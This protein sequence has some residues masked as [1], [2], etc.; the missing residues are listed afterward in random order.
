MMTERTSVLRLLRPNDAL[1]IFY[2]GRSA[3]M[4]LDLRPLDVPNIM[5]SA[6]CRNSAAGHAGGGEIGLLIDERIDE[7]FRRYSRL[8]SE[9]R[10]M[11]KAMIEDILRCRPN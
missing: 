1:A 2:Y 10:L 6:T 9:R 8:I 11:P 7:A 3:A 5:S 4:K